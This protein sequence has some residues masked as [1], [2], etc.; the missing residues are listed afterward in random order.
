[1]RQISI[2]Q[3]FFAKLTGNL[4]LNFTA[5]GLKTVWNFEKLLDQ[6]YQIS[7]N[8][9]M[10]HQI[11]SRKTTHQRMVTLPEVIEKGVT[12]KSSSMQQRFVNKIKQTKKFG[13]SI[14]KVAW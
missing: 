10:Y 11:Q 5:D 9:Q 13:G 3:T 7:Q 12:G 6:I 2:V 14:T 4:L 8:L 1:M